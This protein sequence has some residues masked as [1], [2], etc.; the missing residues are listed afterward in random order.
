MPR[1]LVFG[2][3]IDDVVAVPSGPIRT[4]T[5][6]VSSI[7]FR[8]GGS[9][10]NT[11]SWLGS[12]GADVT[13]IGIVG[14]D[15][16][17]RHT[18]ELERHGVTSRLQT[19]ASLPTGAIVVIV[20]GEKRTMLTERGANAVLDPALVTDELLA[21]VDLL[22]LTGH[23]LFGMDAPERFTALMARA[24][25]AGVQVCLDPG[26][27]GY[28]ADFGV[29]Q[30]LGFFEGASILVPNLEEGRALTGLVEPVAVASA[31]AESFE[32]VALTLDADG[33]VVARR[34][35]APVVIPAVATTILDPTGAGDAFT[36]GFLHTLLV[37]HDLDAAARAGESLASRA[38]SSLGARPH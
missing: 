6:T 27:A 13:F 28:I 26:S 19:H 30:A 11:A 31:L 3:I 2:D 18:L 20:E 9:A 16:A 14:E 32:I 36:A 23:T 4:D 7:R 37:S 12:V 17:A 34:G 24:R 33:V 5:D 1:I 8:P 38:V 22:H 10:A 35:S 25:A 29:E 21:S 15:D